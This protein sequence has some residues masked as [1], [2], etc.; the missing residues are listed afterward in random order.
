[1]D[2]R[3]FMQA[4]AARPKMR[5]DPA[6]GFVLLAAGIALLVAV[7]VIEGR[8]VLRQPWSRAVFAPEGEPPIEGAI[9]LKARRLSIENYPAI[10]DLIDAFRRRPNGEEVIKTAGMDLTE[11]VLWIDLPP[12]EF[13]PVLESGRLPGPGRYEVLA[14]VYCRLD[15][16]EF[17]G[18]RFRV[19]GRLRRGVAG[20]EFAYVFPGDP[21]TLRHFTAET[22]AT[23]GWFHPEGAELLVDALSDEELMF[24]R[25]FVGG[26]APTNPF[27]ARLTL[28]GLMLAAAGGAI[29][30]VRLFTALGE[31]GGGPFR[32]AFRAVSRRPGLLW[33]LHAVFYGGFFGAM[34]LA[35]NF[36]VGQMRFEQMLVQSF[37]SGGPLEYVGEAYASSNILVAAFATW[38]NN[39]VVQTVG[40]TFLISI[41]PFL[42]LLK[43]FVTFFMVGFAMAPSW[44]GAAGPFTYHAITMT[45]ELEGYV[46]ACFFVVVV[47]VNAVRAAF[48]ALGGPSFVA[49]AKLAGSSLLLTG[50]MLGVAALYE[51]TTL[52]LLR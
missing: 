2:S 21:S 13:A 45:L 43:N 33:G 20:L 6:L 39:Y 31:R 32:P 14:G 47:T 48:G 52:I 29:V 27:Y 30:Q 12:A 19:S 37:G 46:F 7:T 10:V 44:T 15:E 38:L 16:F 25:D 17:D 9:P 40:L 36:P 49:V 34:L 35:T 11:W 24:S 26:R 22:G 51:A 23:E 5:H 1:M 41:V 18:R 4:P 8:A 28:L 50:V 3:D 42:G